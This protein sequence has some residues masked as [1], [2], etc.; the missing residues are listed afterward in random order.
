[1]CSVGAELLQDFIRQNGCSTETLSETPGAYGCSC[2]NSSTRS[3]PY[4]TVSALGPWPNPEVD[5]DMRYSPGSDYTS[6][7]Q[8]L[9]LVIRSLVPSGRNAPGSR[10]PDMLWYSRMPWPPAGEP[11]TT[12]TQYQGF[13]RVPN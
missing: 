5:V 4:E 8:N 9:Q 11:R 7:P 10:Y 2:G 12:G 1:M 6:L 13:G 3:A